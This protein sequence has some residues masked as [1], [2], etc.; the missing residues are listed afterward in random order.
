MSKNRR[1][2]LPLGPLL[3]AILSALSLVSPTAPATAAKSTAY[4]G[5]WI[6]V[7]GN[8]LVDGKGT[9]VRL[10]G[11]NRAG[12]EAECLKGTGIFNGPTSAESIRKFVTWGSNA[13]RIPLNET[14]W[15]GINGV[16][17]ATSGPAYRR[18]IVGF[19]SRLE[20][21]GQY[22]ILDLQWAAPGN[23]IAHSLVPLPDAEHAPAF[24]TSVAETFKSNRGVLFD[25]F[26]EPGPGVEWECWLNGC[27]VQNEEVGSYQAVGMQGLVEAVRATGAKQPIM[28]PGT[29]YAHNLGGWMAHLPT[30][31][32][33]ALVASTHAYNFNPCYGHCRGVLVSISHHYPVVTDELGETDCTDNYITPYMNWA[34]RHHI[35]YLA[36]AWTAGPEWGCEEGPSLIENYAGMPTAYG[37]GFRDH[38]RGVAKQER[39]K[40]RRAEAR[41]KS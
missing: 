31:P 13:V 15:L 29:E 41:R 38:L 30:D 32:A 25:L 36:W 35:G 18:A 2:I 37:L 19:V 26:N 20:K 6:G 39:A 16:P 1:V 22:V 28:L 27:Q 40:R 12:S 7:K 23:Q 24:W 3:A 8:Q 21:Q 10:L 33:H 4:S 14:C 34:D 17:A 5:P 11:V 9:P